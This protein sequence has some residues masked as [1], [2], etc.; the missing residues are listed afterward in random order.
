MLPFDQLPRAGAD[1]CLAEVG[2]NAVWR[3][4][5]DRHGEQLGEDGERLL[6]RH[7]DGGVIRNGEAVY[8]GGLAVRELLGALDGIERPAATAL[9]LGVEHALPAER[10]LAGDERGAIGEVDAATQVEGVD[11]AAG[12]DV[13]ARREGGLHT[14]F[15]GE[16]GEAVEEVAHSS[17]GG[18]VGGQ[19][20]VQGAGIVVVAR[21]D[22]G[23]AGGAV[24]TASASDHEYGQ[25]QGG[26]T[27]HD[28][29]A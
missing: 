10:D 21:I 5:C 11:I 1:W 20:R 14:G 15:G 18:D 8:A 29:L 26:P 23:A 12:G 7:D 3:D 28:V 9:D 6:E 16:P 22:D 17:P 27:A 2:R 24:A 19:R 25:K 13:P 4:G